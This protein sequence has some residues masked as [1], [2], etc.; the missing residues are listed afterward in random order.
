MMRTRT[1]GDW[2]GPGGGGDGPLLPKTCRV[3]RCHTLKGKIIRAKH[4][5]KPPAV[6]DHLVLLLKKKK[7][8]RE[9]GEAERGRGPHA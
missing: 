2:L 6:W 3:E 5:V 9:K 8:G 1:D 4:V 7:K